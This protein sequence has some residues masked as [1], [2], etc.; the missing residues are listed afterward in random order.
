MAFVLDDRVYETSTTTGTGDVT[1]D[2]AV[3]SYQSF[4]G[5]G[6]GNTTYYTIAH[7]DANEWE[8]GIGT[9]TAGTTSLSRD[10]ILSS[11][12][13]DA[14]VAFSA[15]TKDVFVAQP[16]ARAFYVDSAG[17]AAV[18]SSIIFAALTVTGTTTLGATASFGTSEQKT[19][20]TTPT[21]DLNGGNHHWIDAD[22]AS[23][24][25]VTLTSPGGPTSGTLAVKQGAT[26][27]DITW[28]AGSGIN[29]IEWIGSEPAWA[30]DPANT[31]RMLSWRF[32]TES[33]GTLYVAGNSTWDVVDDTSPQLGGDLDGNGNT[34]H[35]G[36][37]ENTQTPSGTTATI[38]LGSG[39]H[40]TLNCGSASGDIT[41]TLTMPPGP[42]SGTLVIQ[43]GATPRDITWTASSGTCKWLG[44]EPT[45]NGD[46]NKFRIVS[47]RYW[48]TAPEYLFLSSTDTD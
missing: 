1:L 18:P 33:S 47:W 17:T 2:G 7:Q 40:H 37:A 19:T 34:I 22:Q 45:W 31:V 16:S 8:V 42:T 5:I 46:T 12:N 48:P 13:S 36:T 11:S 27:R 41:V 21:I 6:D 32:T 23:A 43:Q 29:T 44:T 26:P 35:F 3:Q 25:T 9:Y 10:T 4:A 38:D 30:S 15:G 20:G 39:N 14:A 28:T 24:L